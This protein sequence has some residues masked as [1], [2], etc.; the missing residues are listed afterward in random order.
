MTSLL[1]AVSVRVAYDLVSCR[2]GSQ[3]T[4][5]ACGEALDPGDKATAKALSAAFKSAMLQAFCIPVAT[6]DVDASSHRLKQA[7]REPEPVQGWQAWSAD[8]L[9]M[10]G[11]CESLDALDRVR[12]RHGRIA[13]RAQARTAG[14]LCRD[15]RGICE[16]C[17]AAGRSPNS[18]RG[19][20]QVKALETIDG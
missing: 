9:D 7:S 14:T 15:R 8:I 4:I 5:E 18:K 6:E 1:V 19:R 10:I 20:G 13:G 16:T 12:T 17:P 11:V 3:H 2:D